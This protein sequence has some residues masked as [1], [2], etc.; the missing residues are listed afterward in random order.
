MF[1]FWISLR[2]GV[3]SLNPLKFLAHDGHFINTNFF[4]SSSLPIPDIAVTGWDS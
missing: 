3:L 1:A 2:F 4:S